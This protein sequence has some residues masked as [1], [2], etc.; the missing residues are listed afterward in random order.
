MGATIYYK[1][2]VETSEKIN[3]IINLAEDFSKPLKWKTKR[4]NKDGY[5]G[6]IVFPH[7][8][9]E[10]VSLIFDNN[11]RLTS[12]TK[13]TYAPFDIH[14]DIIKLLYCIKKCF[15]RLAVLDETGAWDEY[16]ESH[17]TSTGN[18]SLSLPELDDTQIAEIKAG[19]AQE[20]GISAAGEPFWH[21]NESYCE[22]NFP[23]IRD[24]MRKDLGFKLKDEINISKLIEVSEDVAM[25][26]IIS[27]NNPEIAIIVLTEAWIKAATVNS[28][29]PLKRSIFGWLISHWCFGFN[30]GYLNSFHRKTEKLFDQLIIKTENTQNPSVTMQ[31]F[32]AM[33][34]YFKIKRI[35][36]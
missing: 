9:S 2:R 22:L 19:F 14:Y 12:Y 32:Y 30:G 24:L 4:Y 1:G 36:D 7:E 17:K 21:S 33:L 29:T 8:K 31:V 20:T 34:D 5:T 10:S 11:L 26:G 3:D 28:L 15:K 25:G 18:R 6:I 27:D 35:K 13:T 16:V 23:V